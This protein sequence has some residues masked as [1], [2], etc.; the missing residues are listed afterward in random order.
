MANSR[1]GIGGADLP[2]LPLD[3]T[4]QNSAVA[5]LT[6]A[7]NASGQF[8]H[9]I[10]GEFLPYLQLDPISAMLSPWRCPT[11]WSTGNCILGQNP[12]LEWPHAIYE[13]SLA[14]P[15]SFVGVATVNRNMRRPT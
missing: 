12:E 1:C 3:Y 14:T 11:C 8:G 9:V 10:M 7:V 13:T 15:R 5:W 6:A 2:P 4:D